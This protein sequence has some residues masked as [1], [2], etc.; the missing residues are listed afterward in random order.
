MNDLTLFLTIIFEENFIKFFFLS[1]L[2]LICICFSF[3]WLIYNLVCDRFDKKDILGY[4]DVINVLQNA[5][6]TILFYNL[7]YYRSVNH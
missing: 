2:L 3:I 1:I 5:D 4:C 7:W 6:C